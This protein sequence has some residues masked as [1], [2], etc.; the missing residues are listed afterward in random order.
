M[1]RR[2]QR[3]RMRKQYEA[4]SIEANTTIMALQDQNR[5]LMQRLKDTPP[6]GSPVSATELKLWNDNI[7]L[8]RRVR[9]LQAKVSGLESLLYEQGRTMDVAIRRE[10]DNQV[11]VQVARAASNQ[12]YA[13]RRIAD[14]E[15]HPWRNAF[16][17]LGRRFRR[18]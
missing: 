1:S 3:E 14:M 11:A 10:V 9:E 15:N 6:A 5:V 13:M 2:L 4:Q 18:G 7:N 8:E 17:S 12:R 16:G